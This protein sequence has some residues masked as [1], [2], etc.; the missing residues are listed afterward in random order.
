M[1]VT[2]EY[3]RTVTSRGVIDIEANSE[4]Q[5][6]SI[7]YQKEADHILPEGSEE[8]V[9]DVVDITDMYDNTD[10]YKE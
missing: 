6:E 10:A 5:A 9:D 8:L 3:E 2:I 1:I 4:E 7:F